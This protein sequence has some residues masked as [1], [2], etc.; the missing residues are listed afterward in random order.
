[1]AQQNVGSL[2]INLEARTAQ[3]QQDMSQA[4]RIVGDAMGAIQRDSQRTADALEKLADEGESVATVADMMKAA[5]GAVGFGSLA[6]QLMNVEREFGV[7]SVQLKVATGSGAA[8]AQQFVVLEGLAATLPSTLQEVTGAYVKLKNMGLDPSERA[9]TSYA[10]T[11][12]SMG[13]SL[14]DMIEAVADAA[15]GEFER[16]KEFGIKAKSEGDSVSLTFQGVTTTVANNSGAIEGYLRRIGEVNFAGAATERMATLDGAIS[17]LD[18]SIDGLYRRINDSGAGDAMIA[19]TQGL[20]SNIDQVALGAGALASILGGRMVSSLSASAAAQLA[21]VSEKKAAIV[22][23]SQLAASELVLAERHRELAMQELSR[24][25]MMGGSVIATEAAAVAAA[26]YNRAMAAA[27]V[28]NLAAARSAGVLNAALSLMGGPIGVITTALSI[29]AMAWAY[30]GDSAKSAARG[31]REELARLNKEKQ[32]GA[33]SVGVFNEGIAENNARLVKLRASRERIYARGE[34][35]GG[36]DAEIKKLT[37]ENAAFSRQAAAA[38][39]AQEKLNVTVKSGAEDAV[40]FLSKRQQKEKDLAKVQADFNKATV[41]QNLTDAQLAELKIARAE[42]IGEI[43]E[44]YAD[45]KAKRAAAGRAAQYGSTEDREVANLKSLIDNEQQLAAALAAHG[46]EADKLTPGQK[47][48]NKLLQEQS[49]A[50]TATA[51]AHI[52]RKVALAQDLVVLEKANL[53]QKEMT[54]SARELGDAIADSQRADYLQAGQL[55]QQYETPLQRIQREGREEVGRIDGNNTLSA[56]EQL[57]MRG[58]AQANTGR[59]VDQLQNGLRSEMGAVPESEKIIQ[60]HQEMQRRIVEV[61]AEGSAER[62][63]LELAAGQKLRQDTEALERQ[64]VST[65]LGMSQQVFDGMASLAETA[66]GRQSTAYKVMFLASKAASIA[67]AIVNTEEAATKALTLGPI[68]G[69][70]ASA[71]IRGLGYASVGIMAAQAVQGVAHDGIDNIP[72]EGT[73]LLDRGE[74]VVDSRTN[75]DL[76]DYLKTA[77]GGSEGGMKVVINNMAGV[78][79]QASQS[80]GA[81]GEA[82]LTLDIVRRVAADMVDNK[83]AAAKRPGGALYG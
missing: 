29:G 42:R 37:D 24:A 6:S 12:A 83:L 47:L 56:A 46:V 60:A 21:E 49:V 18:D 68:F 76:K 82:Q 41:G 44:R 45:K 64:K 40:V 70:P 9:I 26:N 33:G 80:T 16:L 19:V 4:K 67:M 74:R 52:G 1:M 25:R 78:D 61:T 15:T 2:I 58:Q 81:N 63:R 66:A 35:T 62:V 36:I 17:N 11:A 30:W 31:A 38:T 59:S 71:M 10:N 48:L 77:R 54:K 55:R 73:W 79:V 75:A 69:V 20:A 57:K 3:I 22:A 8:A 50:I 72:R 39:Q 14:N 65:V 23:N 43:E 53:A 5:L 34:H 13:K 7:L 27:E 28:A 32:F 51:Q